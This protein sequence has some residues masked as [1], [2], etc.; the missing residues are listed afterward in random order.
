M[1]R[2]IAVL[3]FVVLLVPAVF[4]GR[5]WAHAAVRREVSN[6]ALSLT[7]PSTDAERVMKVQAQRARLWRLGGLVLAVALSIAALV[8]YAERAVFLWPGLLI[9]GLLLGVLLGELTRVRPTWATR[10]P[11]RRPQGEFVDRALPGI[12]RVAALA[13]IAL[14]WIATNESWAPE[15]GVVA[16]VGVG[17]WLVVEITLERLARRV[18]PSGSEDIPVDDAL[19][20]NSAHVAVGAGSILTLLLLSGLLLVGGIRVGDSASGADLTPVALIAGAFGAVVAALVVATFLMR[21]L[22][23]VRWAEAA[24]GTSRRG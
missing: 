10:A 5:V 23:P 6:G 22:V 19:R 20:I 13:L 24:W 15:A 4:V 16:A 17:G 7:V 12:G 1:G 3:L 9:G 18:A 14:G 2:F 8:L 21:W 11:A